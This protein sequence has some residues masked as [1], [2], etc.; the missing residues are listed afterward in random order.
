MKKTITA[1]ILCLACLSLTPF[2][3][4]S[5]EY[6]SS[7]YKEC[8]YRFFA[9]AK[10]LCAKDSPPVE[11]DCGEVHKWRDDVCEEA[12]TDTGVEMDW[13]SFLWAWHTEDYYGEPGSRA[14]MDD[15]Y[16]VIKKSCG[17]DEWCNSDKI[18]WKNFRQAAEDKW[19]EYSPKY[20]NFYSKA[21]TYGIDGPE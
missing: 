8:F 14:T 6:G 13:L 18:Y 16:D 15:I 5:F 7:D 3:S 21:L 17:S 1:A 19:G 11:F 10:C 2:E 12:G 9:S 20:K 4:D